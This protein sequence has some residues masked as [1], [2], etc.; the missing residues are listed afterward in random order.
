[1]Y[2]QISADTLKELFK[3]WKV[4]N[5]EELENK[6]SNI[7][8]VSFKFYELSIECKNIIYHFYSLICRVSTNLS[9]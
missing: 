8:I 2:E 3:I 7:S 5:I 4:K 1:M 9:V 6:T